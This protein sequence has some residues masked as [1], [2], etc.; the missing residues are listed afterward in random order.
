MRDDLAA[1]LK[2]VLT[3]SCVLMKVG[4]LSHNQIIT[5]HQVFCWTQA[6]KTSGYG[7]SYIASGY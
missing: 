6:L 3:K 5:S 1:M 4:V 2:I 7:N